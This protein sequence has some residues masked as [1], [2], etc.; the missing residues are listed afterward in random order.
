V[1]QT[2]GGKIALSS[3]PRA[4]L[5][6]ASGTPSFSPAEEKDAT[7]DSSPR[8]IDVTFESGKQ[9]LHYRLIEKIGEGGMGVVWKAEDT[10]LRRHVALKFVPEKS[11][12]DRE[13]VDRHLREARAAS[14]LNHPNIC[15]IYDIG[16]WEG[17][18]FIVMELLEGRSLADQIAGTSMAV[19]T[20][21][22]LATQVADALAAAHARGIIHRDIKPA[23]IFIVDD[24]SPQPRAKMLDFGLAKLALSASSDGDDETVTAMA[25]TT[26]GAVV[27]TVAYMSPEQALGKP[28]DHRTDIFSLGAVLYEMITGTRAFAGDTSAAVFD[29]I[30]NRAPTAS[31]ELDWNV[32]KG[33]ERVLDKALEKDPTLRYQSAADL[34]ADLRRVRRDL[35]GSG[36]APAAETAVASRATAV[37][38]F[39]ILSGESEDSFLSLALAEAVSHGLSMNRELVVRPTSAVLKY[40]ESEPDPTRVARDLNVTV[41]V[42]GSIQKLGSN[43]RV[44]VQVWDASSDST[45]LSVRLDGHMNDLFGLQ[46]ELAEKL[47]AGL[48][49]AESDRSMAE[50]PI[51]DAEAYELFLRANERLHRYT[52]WDTNA[53]IEMF[54]SC[55]QLDPTFSS[56]WARLAAACVSMGILIDPD[57]KWFLEAEQAVERALALDP[58]DPEAW[59]ARGKLLWAPSKG[60]QHE[61]ALRDL[62]RACNHPAAP[63]DAVLWRAIVLGHVGLHDEAINGLN[64]ALEAQPDDLMGLLVMGETLGWKGNSAAAVE[65]LTRCVHRDP[66]HKY[67]NLFLPMAFLYVDELDK[68]E[69]VLKKS[70]DFTGRDSML[71]TTEAMLW[72]KRGECERA[73][74]LVE[75]ALEHRRSLSHDHHTHHYA[76]AVY[77]TLGDG[78]SAVKELTRAAHGGMPNYPA[79]SNDRHLDSLHERN[80]FRTLLADLERRWVTLKT[81]FGEVQDT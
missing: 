22:R 75:T 59:T 39:K 60:F 15:S 55:V 69:V 49:I 38:P 34:S 44:Q 37:L 46:D 76:A 67:A 52:Q 25:V 8:G 30:L 28:V 57:P 79:F 74:N 4:L 20:A 65:Y 80:D 29:A 36:P 73:A 26:P 32:P 47:G 18:Q 17:R 45:V 62:G 7:R 12:H 6:L 16:E 33:L 68:A 42:E 56:G 64:E 63:L 27:G 2:A 71:T 81:E 54:R 78:A 11:A 24:G 53:A 23:N 31:A 61:A 41:V 35:A 10:R 9:I 5:L 19:D 1:Q 13:A 50:S 51:R 21:T 43:I 40:A 72:A 66:T 77:A 70:T 3:H 14:A 48:G 58:S